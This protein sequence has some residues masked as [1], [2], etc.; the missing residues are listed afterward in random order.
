[1]QLFV[2]CYFRADCAV[3]GEDPGDAFRV[4]VD[5]VEEPGERETKDGSQ[6]KHPDHHLLLDWSHERHVGPEHVHE[7]QTE[8]KQ[9]ACEGERDRERGD[10]MISVYCHFTSS[11]TITAFKELSI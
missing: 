2:V 7:A 5:C 11:H 6:E 8:E 3:L 9:T 1:M 10:E 4:A